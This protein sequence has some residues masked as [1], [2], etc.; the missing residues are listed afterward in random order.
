MPCRL[1]H[2]HAATDAAT[3][4]LPP[5]TRSCHR[6]LPHRHALLPACLPTH[7]QSYRGNP[8]QN[9]RPQRVAAFISESQSMTYRGDQ[10]VYSYVECFDLMVLS[11]WE[12][13]TCSV[14]LWFNAGG[15]DVPRP[16]DLY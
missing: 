14:V 5:T 8:T 3:V 4:A 16:E 13:E 10:A 9:S 6:G 1:S 12:H 2:L 11:G 7:E 15:R